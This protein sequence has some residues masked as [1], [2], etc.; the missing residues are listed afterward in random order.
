M[1]INP[2]SLSAVVGVIYS[3][4]VLSKSGVCKSI[5]YVNLYISTKTARMPHHK[6]LEHV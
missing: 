3:A 1:I 6:R 4:W 5:S 2:L